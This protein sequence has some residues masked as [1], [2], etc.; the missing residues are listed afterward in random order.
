MLE[1]ST[2]P[3][4]GPRMARGEV[5]EDAVCLSAF[6]ALIIASQLREVLAQGHYAIAVSLP[7]DYLV[8]SFTSFILDDF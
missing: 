8:W 2:A 1:R 4:S 5:G 3:K 6:K 7:R